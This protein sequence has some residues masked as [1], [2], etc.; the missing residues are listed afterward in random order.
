MP[1][2]CSCDDRETLVYRALCMANHIDKDDLCK[3]ELLLEHTIA[4]RVFVS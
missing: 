1:S 4:T 3:E 2:V